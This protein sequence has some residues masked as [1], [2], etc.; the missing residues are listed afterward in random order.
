M[1][2]QLL[3]VL[4]RFFRALSPDPEQVIEV[5]M[6]LPEDV[7]LRTASSRTAA[8][9]TAG[10]SAYGRIPGP[11]CSRFWSR[12]LTFQLLIVAVE[13]VEVL[14][15]FLP[16]QYSL[17]AEQIVDDPV[18]RRRSRGDFQGLHRGQ[19][20]TAFFEQIADPARRSSRFSA[21]SG[22]AAS[23]SISPEHAVLRGFHTFFL[24]RKKC[25][26]RWPGG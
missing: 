1:V 2:E 23:S 15:V 3:D 17:T 12:T 13:L 24:I 18:P 16:G 11:C 20:S 19:S 25:G 9:G 7:S 14:P 22:P 6:I 4:L 26:G 8:G 21:S 10:G 5:P